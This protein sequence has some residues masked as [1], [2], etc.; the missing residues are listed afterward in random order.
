MFDL[1]LELH[2]S[3]T[4]FE[5]M[6]QGDMYGGFELI[7]NELEDGC[8][9]KLYDPC[10]EF[11]H[12]NK[13]EMKEEAAKISRIHNTNTRTI[14]KAKKELAKDVKQA[15]MSCIKASLDLGSAECARLMK[16]ERRQKFVALFQEIQAWDTINKFVEG[17]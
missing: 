6:T 4:A 5:K 1:L 14:Y 16:Q 10:V 12:F 13:E 15:Q 7:Y 11:A 3:P 9:E 2:E 8:S 17:M